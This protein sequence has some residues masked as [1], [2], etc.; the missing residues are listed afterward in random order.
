[1]IED[2]N[3]L[4]LAVGLVLICFHKQVADYIFAQERWLVDVLAARGW[5]IPTFRSEQAA[6]DLYFCLGAFVCVVA[7]L[8]IWLGA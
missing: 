1:M 6:H 4:R 5:K 7:L 8:R 2:L 3:L